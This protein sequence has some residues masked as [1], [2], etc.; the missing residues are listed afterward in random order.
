MIHIVYYHTI[1]ALAFGKWVSKVSKVSKDFRESGFRSLES[2][3][4]KTED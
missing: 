4:R 1:F 2:N 3:G